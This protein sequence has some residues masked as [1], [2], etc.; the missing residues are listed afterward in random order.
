MG[1][2][3]IL[4]SLLLVTLLGLGG[5]NYKR[6]LDLERTDPRVFA[7]YS[8]QDIVVMKA[9]MQGEVAKLEAAYEASMSK[10]TRMRA[11]ASSG[12]RF[13]DFKQVQ[14]ATHEVRELGM[15]VSQKLKVLRDLEREAVYRAENGTALRLHLRRLTTI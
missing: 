12:D 14:E 15:I 8:D 3:G 7:A 13:Q 1:R 11:T 5:W 6:N 2:T 4:A 10:D 9:A